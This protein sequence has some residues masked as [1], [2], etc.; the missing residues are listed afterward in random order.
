LH[1]PALAQADPDPPLWPSFVTFSNRTQAAEL[2]A[3]KLRHYRGKYPLILGIPRGS[4]PM[5]KVIADKLEGD[6]DVVLVH[7]IGAPDN[8]EFAIG[9]VSEFGTI[10]RSEGVE[11]YE[12][13]EEF[14]SISQ[15][16]DDFPQVEDEEVLQILSEAGEKGKHKQ[17]V[18]SR[19]KTA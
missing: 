19:K 5:A 4:V 7:K 18:P 1:E 6:L 12:I 3:E 10:Y 2:V 16:Y 14:F 8:P 11:F 15:F 13:P 17:A 9:S